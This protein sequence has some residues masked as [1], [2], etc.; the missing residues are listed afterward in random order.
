MLK[1]EDRKEVEI[2]LKEEEENARLAKFTTTTAATTT[3]VATTTVTSTTTEPYDYID[4]F[5]DDYGNIFRD[6]H[7]LLPLKPGVNLCF[8]WN[9]KD[10]EVCVDCLLIM[11]LLI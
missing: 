10:K 9:G 2:N 5:Y 11:N 4:D 6:P 3:T 1:D 8:D 7:V